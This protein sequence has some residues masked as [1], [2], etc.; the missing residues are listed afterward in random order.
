MSYTSW[1]EA[2]KSVGSGEKHERGDVWQTAAGN[3]RGKNPAGDPQSYVDQDD[4]ASI[5]MLLLDR[6]NIY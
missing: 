1:I 2:V 3:W 6:Q 4:A 5:P